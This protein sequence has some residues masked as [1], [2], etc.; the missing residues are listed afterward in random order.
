MRL[1]G[2][3]RI[4]ADDRP[5]GVASQT[6]FVGARLVMPVA[7]QDVTIRQ[8]D[9]MPVAQV[10]SGAAFRDYRDVLPHLSPVGAPRTNDGGLSAVPFRASGQDFKIGRAACRERGDSSGGCLS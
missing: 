9:Q 3:P 7:E 2:L 10:L 6:G 1:P 5:D 8:L 4:M